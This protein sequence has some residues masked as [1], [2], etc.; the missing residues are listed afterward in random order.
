MNSAD[1]PGVTG[2]E[3]VQLTAQD[4]PALN[5]MSHLTNTQ[6]LN[7][8]IGYCVMELKPPLLGKKCH[9]VAG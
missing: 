2:Y 3:T 7:F 9:L 6:C 5:L 4:I 8:V 1:T